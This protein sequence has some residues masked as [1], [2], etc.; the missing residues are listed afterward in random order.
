[1]ERKNR[2]ETLREKYGYATVDG[3]KLEIA[4]WT[5]EPSCIFAGRGDHPKRGKWKQG[6]AE[7]NIVLNL[8]DPASIPEG[9]WK[10]VVWEPEKMYIAK[11]E[12]KL[13][14]KISTSGFRTRLF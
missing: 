2:R 11:W 13:S 8:S 4:N 14:G 5:A 9:K 6:P 3:R 10:E 7:E 12:D 1:M